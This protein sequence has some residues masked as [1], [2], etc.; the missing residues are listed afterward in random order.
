MIKLF[1][2]FIGLALINAIPFDVISYVGI[3]GYILINFAILFTIAKCV[4]FS[5][6]NKH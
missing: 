2:L 5:E 1:I 6:I 3:I 4:T